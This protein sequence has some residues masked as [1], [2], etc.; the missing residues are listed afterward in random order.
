MICRLSRQDCRRNVD[1]MKELGIE[2][3]IVNVLEFVDLYFG[4][5]TR[6]NNDRFFHILLHGY[7]HCSCAKGRPKK[8][9][10]VSVRKDCAPRNISLHQA[11]EV[12]QDRSNWRSTV[13]QAGC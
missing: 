11:T 5:V 8:K 3:D 1:I 12:S 13:F 2:K 6:I 10:I 7:T 4:H 9:W